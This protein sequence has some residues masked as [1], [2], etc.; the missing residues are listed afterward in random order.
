MC[1]TVTPPLADCESGIFLGGISEGDEG[2]TTGATLG[3]L[4]H[5]WPHARSRADDTCSHALH[6]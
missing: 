2:E 4:Q 6:H 3:R 5:R 1:G